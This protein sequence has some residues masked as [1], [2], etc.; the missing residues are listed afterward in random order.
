MQRIAA[1]V[2]KFCSC[3]C[4]RPLSTVPWNRG[5]KRNQQVS[6][7]C[8]SASY[9]ITQVY[10]TLILHNLGTF[11]FLW[12]K[13]EKFLYLTPILGGKFL[14][15]TQN[16][17]NFPLFLS[18]KFLYFT[19]NML[20]IPLFLLFFLSSFFKISN[21]NPDLLQV[22]R[23]SNSTKSLPLFPTKKCKKISIV[24]PGDN[25]G[26]RSLHC[27]FPKCKPT[28][29]SDLHKLVALVSGYHYLQ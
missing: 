13:I 20:I 29:H 1:A 3:S 26:L 24:Y 8:Q 2:S 10:W 11:I 5:L 16:M 6:Q 27:L 22:I 19:Q 12:Q 9:C 18:G 21:H 23:N 14:Y 7:L 28:Q 15:L 17:P 25:V 4:G